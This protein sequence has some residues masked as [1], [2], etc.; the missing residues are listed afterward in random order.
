M[1]GSRNRV[2]TRMGTG[3][4]GVVA[5]GMGLQKPKCPEAP[6]RPLQ[7]PPVCRM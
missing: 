4:R 5:P 6:H 3:S 7:P 1:A 2:N